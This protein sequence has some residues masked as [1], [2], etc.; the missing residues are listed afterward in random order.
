MYEGLN[1]ALLVFCCCISQHGAAFCDFIPLL[2]CL[3]SNS[4]I[5]GTLRTV[6]T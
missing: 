3:R 2:A 6:R 5:V 1:E 4:I